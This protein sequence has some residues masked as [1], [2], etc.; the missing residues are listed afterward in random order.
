VR[1]AAILLAAAG[2][3]ALGVATAAGGVLP[4]TFTVVAENA[5]D[6]VDDTPLIEEGALLRFQ[7]NDNV[8]HNVTAKEKGPDGK[9]LFRSGNLQGVDTP[10]GSIV[11][12][13]GTQ[14]L[15]AGIYDF[16]CTIHPN[17]EGTLTVNEFPA[18]PVA[19]P[20]ISLKVKSK[21]LEKVVKSGKL[22]V[23]VSAAEPTDAEGI[24][25][26]ASK[27]R[28]TITKSLKLDLAAGGTQTAKLKLK[29]KAAEKLGDLE[30]AKVRVTGIVD[31]GFGD[32]ASKKLK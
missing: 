26:Q 11:D 27:G 32:K 6:F 24:S 10:P 15:D 30:K 29:K 16:E 1:G 22:K 28:K 2:A 25:L 8:T 31:F 18:G 9:A 19:R 7:N 3:L 21:K 20:E 5:D 12:V 14:F 4:G 17:M 13:N 23:Q